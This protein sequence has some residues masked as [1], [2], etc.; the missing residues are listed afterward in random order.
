VKDENRRRKTVKE[1]KRSKNKKRK[2]DM[3]QKTFH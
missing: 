1:K 2:K 3:Y